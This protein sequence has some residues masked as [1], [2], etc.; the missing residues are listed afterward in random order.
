MA[1]EGGRQTVLAT[2]SG[3]DPDR[4]RRSAADAPSV[5]ARL[6][7][8]WGS[9]ALFAFEVGADG[10]LAGHLAAL[11][12]TPVAVEGE[13]GTGRATVRARPPPDPVAVAEAVRADDP[14]VTLVRT[15][16]A[17]RDLLQVL[18]RLTDR[19]AEV[20]R[21]AYEAGYYERTRAATGEDVAA[22]LDISPA[23]FSQHVRAA[24]SRLLEAIFDAS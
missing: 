1:Q 22:R 5:E 16:G 7:G 10:S 11:D 9:D 24:E 4:V 3:A 20:L 18:R 19:Q 6:L 8:R 13:N 2:V 14:A 21:T 23:T 12:A 17:G 15:R